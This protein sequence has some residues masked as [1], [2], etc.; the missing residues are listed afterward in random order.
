[1]TMIAKF[2]EEKMKNVPVPE[3][4]DGGKFAQKTGLDPFS[5]NYYIIRDRLYY[6]EE[7]GKVDLSDCVTEPEPAYVAER[8]EAYLDAGCTV[9]AM[10]VA[11]W[12]L[13]VEGRAERS[14]E[15]QA[16]REEV[17]GRVPASSHTTGK[18]DLT[19]E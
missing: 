1:M 17:K 18:K 3:H 6:P 13:L 7:L 5:G 10:V 2:Q 16:R 11:M 19:E 15:L 12:E 4:F 9:E 14:Q 8:R